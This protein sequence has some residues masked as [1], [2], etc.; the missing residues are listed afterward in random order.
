MG[1]N[2]TADNAF[3]REL[4]WRSLSSSGQD[5]ALWPRQPRFKSWQGH[6]DNLGYFEKLASTYRQAWTPRQCDRVAKVMD[7][8]SIGLC[9][10]GFKSPR[11]RCCEVA[12][13]EH[14]MLL[15]S[16]SSDR[17]LSSVARA[18]VL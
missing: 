4:R 1:S 11:C 17:S 15:P 7:S 18:M 3:S 5:V 8:K 6:G 9:P 10:Q 12:A 13:P 14:F 16:T 2:P